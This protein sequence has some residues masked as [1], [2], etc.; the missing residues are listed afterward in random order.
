MRRRLSAIRHICKLTGAR[1]LVAVHVT[2]WKMRL[3]DNDWLIHHLF[4][5][6]SRCLLGDAHSLFSSFSS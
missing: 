3:W 2:R 1:L 6:I 5:R 4:P